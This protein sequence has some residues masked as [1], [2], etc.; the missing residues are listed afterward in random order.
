MGVG[1]RRVTPRLSLWA[2]KG[3]MVSLTE[4]EI[5]GRAQGWGSAWRVRLER[6]A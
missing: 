2:S 5:Q 1:R 3:V 6:R 4:T